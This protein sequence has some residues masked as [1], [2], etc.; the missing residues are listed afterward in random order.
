M[1]IQLSLVLTDITGVT[2]LAMLRA[3][4]A[5]ER[6]PQQ[7]AQF[8]QSGCKHSEAE[9]A[10]ALT[11]TWDDAQL[12]VLHQA[13]DLFDYYTAKIAECDSKVEQHYQAM[14]SRGDKHAPLPD[15]PPAKPDSKSK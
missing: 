11:G 10:K 9:I 3:I 13:L 7:L 1:T 15:L 6:D 14:E 2:G 12:F 5:G 8:R 4:I